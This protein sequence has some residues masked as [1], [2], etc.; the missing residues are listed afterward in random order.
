MEVFL[1]T[2]LPFLS[3]LAFGIP[4]RMA[5]A[6]STAG[7]EAAFVAINFAE[8][9]YISLEFKT[10]TKKKV[11]QCLVYKLQSLLQLLMV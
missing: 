11:K 1:C 2:A 6:I 4:E 10:A 9:Q 5:K 7:N 8:T 3:T